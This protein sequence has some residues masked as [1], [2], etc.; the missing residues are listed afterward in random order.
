MDLLF[1]NARMH[2]KDVGGI[3]DSVGPDQTAA[4]G[5]VRSGSTLFAET[6]LLQ[7]LEFLWYISDTL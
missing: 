6:H 4:F 3:S 1:S 5:A 7:H 2:P